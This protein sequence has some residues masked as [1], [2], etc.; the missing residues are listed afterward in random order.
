MAKHGQPRPEFFKRLMALDKVLRKKGFPAMSPWWER[1]LE[2]FY[3]DEAMDL[4]LRVGRRGGKS[5]TFCRVAVA[6]GIYGEHVITPGDIGVIPLVSVDRRESTGRIRNIR[7]ILD[8]I[9]MDYR[10]TRDEIELKHKPV[11]FKTFTATIAGV[12]GFTAICIL[13]DEV[14]KWKDSDTGVNPAGEVISSIKPTIA[15]QPLA[16]VFMCS[17]PWST[18]DAHYDAFERGNIGT[19]RVAYAPTWEANPSLTEEATHSLERDERKWLR[20]YKGI[21]QAAISNA[22]DPEVIDDSMRSPVAAEY[23]QPVLVID[24]SSGGGDAFTY[25][26]VEWGWPTIQ[27][28]PWVTEWKY[29]VE[30]FVLDDYGNRV[31][32]KEYEKIKAKVRPFIRF[33]NIDAFEGRF[34]GKIRADE[35]VARLA[36]I[37][38][39]NGAEDVHSDQREAMALESL[40]R[41]AGLSFVSHTWSQPSK[42]A[43]VSSLKRWLSERTIIIEPNALMRRELGNFAEKVTPGGLITYGARGKAHDDYVALLL[44][45]AMA[46]N[47]GYVPSSPMFRGGK[48][49]H[50]ESLDERTAVRL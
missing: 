22:F 37:C 8:A 30:Y 46:D 44:T 47:S 50:T 7:A 34:K 26:L 40:F 2:E 18:L 28:N 27:E 36:S 17:S 10:D 15:T 4:V 43:A 42:V 5:S 12:S 31:P 29:G 19:Q 20:E 38:E 14:S 23:G 49:K 21:P 16:R 1:V 41:E 25:C 45:A 3:C 9:N 33:R 24:P 35:I 6:E 13:L 48:G 39:D 11:L 32:N